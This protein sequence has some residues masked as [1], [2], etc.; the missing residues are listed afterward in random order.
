MALSIEED[1]RRSAS[2]I[3]AAMTGDDGVEPRCPGYHIRRE[4]GEPDGI[5]LD[6]AD[7]GPMCP[8]EL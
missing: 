3:E 2:P 5:E 4:L 1:G 6:P 7:G 8:A